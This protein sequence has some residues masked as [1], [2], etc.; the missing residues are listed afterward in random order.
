[1]DADRIVTPHYF[2]NTK[3][4]EG[5]MVGAL[6]EAF[7]EA[8]DAKSKAE[9]RTRLQQ[10][11]AVLSAEAKLPAQADADRQD[12]AILAAGAKLLSGELNCTECHRFH[13]EG[14]LGSAPDLTGYGSRD[15]LQG[16][17]A[18][19]QHPRFYPEERNDR[20]PAF[21]ESQQNPDGNLLTTH[22]LNLL[23]DWLRGDWY[24][25]ADA[26]P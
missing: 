3:L 15:W 11:A 14:E 12:T 19:P 17:I 20:M 25:P 4:T 8:S 26:T 22:E 7:G 9:L 21:C 1:L 10:V 2:G 5:D 6:T 18:N 13:D 23:V 16:M 24:H